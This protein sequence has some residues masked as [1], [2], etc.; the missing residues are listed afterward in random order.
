M[1]ETRQYLY[2]IQPTRHDMLKEGLTPE[3]EEIMR[4]HFAYLL[5]LTEEGVMILVGRT[6]TTDED[7]MGIAI[8]KARSDEEARALMN[9]IQQ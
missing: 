8:F 4:E 6:L 9:E 7:S 2:K 5:R 3:E 1:A